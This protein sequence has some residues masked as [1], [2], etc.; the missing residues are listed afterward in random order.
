MRIGYVGLGAMGRPMAINL[1]KAGH[2][3]VV[4]DPD[5]TA[6]SILAQRGAQVAKSARETADEAEGS[7]G[8]AEGRPSL[9]GASACAKRQL[10]NLQP[11]GERK[12]R[13]GRIFLTAAG[14]QCTRKH[15]P[16]VL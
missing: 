16:L 2:D 10:R 4:C 13:H 15:G 14:T 12:C 3:L 8:V 9:H 1:A 11:F 5:D 7:S 6:T